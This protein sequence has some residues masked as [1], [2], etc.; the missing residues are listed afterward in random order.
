MEA[1]ALETALD[2]LASERP[3]IRDFDLSSD[4][5]EESD[6]VCGGWVSILFHLLGSGDRSVFRAASGDLAE[7]R[8]GLLLTSIHFF[9]DSP[10]IQR[11]WVGEQNL[12]SISQT[13]L[14][15]KEGAAFL[16]QGKPC[17]LKTLP[18]M[19][20]AVEP[21]YPKPKLIIAG[22]GH[23]GRAVA[24][25][26]RNLDFEVTILDDRP[27][28]ARSVEE[29][30]KVIVGNISESLAAIPLAEDCF[31][32]IVTRGHRHDSEALKACLGRKSAYIGMIGSARKIKLMRT[33]FLENSWATETQ[34]DEIFAP[35]GLDIGSVT[36]QEI[37]VSIAAQL[38]KIRT[39]RLKQ[40]E[41]KWFGP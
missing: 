36:V 39:A 35:I 32:V 30:H 38:V 5:I 7:G 13:G 12:R 9:S 37:A 6:A 10:D 14:S 11:Q 20:L 41:G 28:L 22:A 19:W 18:G 31:I 29:A 4:I 23:V 8:K 33:K 25:L 27:D 40:R 1:Q 17:L 21:A 3:D 34:L 2:C 26:G 16:S 15:E 24:H